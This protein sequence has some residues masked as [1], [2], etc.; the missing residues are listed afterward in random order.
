VGLV[1]IFMIQNATVVE[2]RFLFWSLSMSRALLMF[3]LLAIGI[4]VGWTLHSLSAHK[5]ANQDDKL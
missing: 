4:V 3:F 2:L 5:S 1:V